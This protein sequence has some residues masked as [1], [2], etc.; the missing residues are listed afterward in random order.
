MGR[1]V[2]WCRSNGKCYR[3]GDRWCRQSLNGAKGGRELVA[4]RVDPRTRAELEGEGDVVFRLGFTW[5]RVWAV[6][7]WR[8]TNCSKIQ[9]VVFGCECSQ[10]WPFPN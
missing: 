9:F 6:V 2:C 1:E 4:E 8:Y 7:G 10:C 5:V 3:L